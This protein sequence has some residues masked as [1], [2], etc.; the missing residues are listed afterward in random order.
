MRHQNCRRKQ[1][2]GQGSGGIISCGLRMSIAQFKKTGVKFTNFFQLSE[3]QRFTE[4]LH[5]L[6]DPEVNI[7]LLVRSSTPK[8]IQYQTG[9]KRKSAVLKF[10]NRRQKTVKADF[11]K[12]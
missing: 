10:Q 9:K 12:S 5:L 11:K 2:L 1:Y 8:H 3:T 4:H 6:F 7:Q